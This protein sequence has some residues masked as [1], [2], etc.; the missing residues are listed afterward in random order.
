M[1]ARWPTAAIAVAI[2]VSLVLAAPAAAHHVDLAGSGLTEAELR[3]FETFVLGAEHAA[4][5][6]RRRARIVA[7]SRDAGSDPAVPPLEL[8]TSLRDPFDDALDFAALATGG[9]A[10]EPAGAP[11]LEADEADPP[12][13][14]GEWGEPFELP[15]YAIHAAL[16]PTGKVMWFGPWE[17]SGVATTTWAILWDPA[18]GDLERV[19]PPPLTPGGDPA[20]IY[21]AGHAFLASGELLVAGGTLGRDAEG[22]PYG[23]NKVYTFDPFS[24]TWTEQPD[25]EHGRWYPTN[26]Q[27]PDG[28]QAIM[29]GS[30]EFGASEDYYNETIELF[31][32]GATIGSQGTITT[33]VDENGDPA[34]RGTPGQPPTGGLYPHMFVMPSGKTLVAGPFQTDTWYLH[35]P[36]SDDELE[37]NG[38]G[39]MDWRRRYASAVIMPP[40]PGDTSPSTK[41]LVLGGYGATLDPETS[42][43]SLDSTEYF[44][45]AEPWEG[46]RYESDMQVARSNQNAVLLP[47]GSMVQVG[48]GVGADLYGTVPDHHKVELWD[49]ATGEWRLGAEQAEDRAYHS[50][51][52]LL[53][54]GR[55]VSAGDDG[56]PGGTDPIDTA[57][58]YSPPYL[59][60]GPRPTISSA[61]DTVELSDTFDVETPDDDVVE[62]AL[63]APGATTHANDMHQRY[64]PLA[65]TQEAD[66]VQLTAPP[67]A[68]AAPPGY[69][70]LFLVN[71]AGVPSIAEFVE[72]VPDR[73]D[74]QITISE[75]AI[76]AGATESFQFS[77]DLGSFS[78]GNGET[79]TVS[80]PAGRHDV[81]QSARTGWT[82]TALSCSDGS[83]TDLVQR[84]ARIQ[85]SP[86]ESVLCSFVDS[87]PPSPPPDGDPPELTQASAAGFARKHV[88]KRLGDGT[89]K[90]RRK[91]ELTCRRRS[92][93]GFR[94]AF[95]LPPAYTGAL[96]VRD[97][98]GGRPAAGRFSFA[99][100][101][102]SLGRGGPTSIKTANLP[103]PSVRELIRKWLVLGGPRPRAYACGLRPAPKRTTCTARGKSFSFKLR[104]A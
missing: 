71:E 44:D 91:V 64:V 63:I 19:D 75:Q 30:D 73:P 25:M 42:G 79:K 89:A 77:G 33:L 26:V 2:A 96:L 20:N 49:P 28:R 13:E 81:T 70:M 65:V 23:L 8:A 54:D 55:V 84:R 53:P 99:G 80:V 67:D 104:G 38:A 41:A 36:G 69:Y 31:T 58:V 94:C 93:G 7:A 100:A 86:G 59:F 83:S 52:L 47:D 46:W 68:N 32:P 11:Q 66:G 51:A 102:G 15:L 82:L 21:C 48:G 103:C 17:P 56:N 45:D 50:T 87:G 57:E 22:Q 98:G 78:L 18:T 9:G 95:R 40:P 27:L 1:T 43:K 85:V 37:W 74:G 24:E 16:L 39:D 92:D 4:D 5:H 72:V 12:A 76:P 3:S 6:A 10:Y 101:C 90:A 35:T 34:E 29:S 60:K 61:P 88:A 97:A 62:A 14:D